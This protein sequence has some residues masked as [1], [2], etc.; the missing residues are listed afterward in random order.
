MFKKNYFY[1]RLSYVQKKYKMIENSLL[2]DTVGYWRD[3][4]KKKKFFEIM[5]IA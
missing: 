2:S 4:K 5:F 1:K 3:K